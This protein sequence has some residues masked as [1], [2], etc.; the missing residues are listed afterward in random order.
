MAPSLMGR[1]RRR[2]LHVPHRFGDRPRSPASR[3]AMATVSRCRG[4]ATRLLAHGIQ[5][6]AAVHIGA[7]HALIVSGKRAIEDFWR[8]A[9]NALGLTDI[10]LKTVD[11]E[12]TDDTAYEVGEADLKIGSG[13]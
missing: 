9:A 7:I 13:Q 6:E 8:T 2:H 4:K 11:L 3:S 10:T 1:R 5:E 12:V